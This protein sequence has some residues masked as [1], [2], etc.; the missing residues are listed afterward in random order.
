M[1]QQWLHRIF[2][3]IS[4]LFL[5]YSVALPAQHLP[6]AGELIGQNK[7]EEARLLLEKAA[8]QPSNV[9][10]ATLSLALLD[11]I[12]DHE[13]NLSERF[14]SI[15]DQENLYPYYYALWRNPGLAG[16][17]GL[18]DEGETEFI[19]SLLNDPKTP[20]MLRASAKYHLYH[21]RVASGQ[22]KKTEGILDGVSNISGWQYTGP[23]ENISESGFDKE[24]PPVMQYAADSRFKAMN[25]AD[26]QWFK[27][28]Y[29]YP[30]PWMIV[31][32]H[33]K[34]NVGLAY[35]Q[36]FVTSPAEMDVVISS[37]F[38]GTSLKVW[39][40]DQQ[41]IAEREERETDFDVYQ[42]PVHLQK[43]VNRVL[44]QIGLVSGDKTNFSARFLDKSGQVV[45]GLVP[46]S[47]QPYISQKNVPAPAPI[48]VFAEAWFEERIRENPNDWMSMYYLCEAYLRSDKYREA[49]VLA[50]RMLEKYPDALL[51]RYLRLR[52]YQG[53]NNRTA[54]TQELEDFRRI[55]PGFLVSAIYS[56]KEAG[57]NE[58]YEEAQKIL[59]RWVNRYDE[60]ETT[61][62]KQIELY[63]ARKQYQEAI[64]LIEDAV[65]KYPEN[66]YFTTLQHNVEMQV[67]KRPNAAISVYE[68]FLKRNYTF[69]IA[70]ALAS[71]Y[72]EQGMNRKAIDTY[73]KLDEIFRGETVSANALFSFYY[74][75][76]DVE[77]AQIWLDKLLSIAPYHS[78][79]WEKAG[80]LAERAKDKEKALE[81]Y[82]KALHYDPNEYDA[83]RKIRELQG[84][85][86]IQSLFPQIDAFALYKK[87][88]DSHNTAEFGWYY[89]L[90]DY[91]AIL[92]PER[93]S[94]SFHTLV[95]KITNEE[96]INHWKESS[97][98]YG[99]NQRLVIEKAEILKPGGSRIAA[100]Q[101]DNSLVFPNLEIG[102]GIYVRYRLS[103]YAFGRMAR[104]HFDTYFLNSQVPSELNRFVLI[105]PDNIPLRFRNWNTAAQPVE[106][107]IEGDNMKSWTWEL[108][109][110]Q[111]V[112]GE[113]NTAPSSDIAQVVHISSLNSWDEVASWYADVSATQAKP[114]YEVQQLYQELFPKGT[115]FTQ[116]EKAKA[117]YRWI[118]TNIR[119]SSVPFRQSGFIP[120]KAAKV[121]QTKLGDCKDL[122]TLYAA[123]A[124]EAGMKANL[125]LVN[126]RDEGEHAMEL[127]SIEFNHCI[128]KV[129][130]DETPYYLELTNPELPFAALSDNDLNAFVLEIPF[131][132][133]DQVR[134]EP[135]LLDPSNRKKDRRI[136]K[137]AIE[138]KGRELT[139][140]T[141]AMRFGGK[142]ADTRNN[143][144]NLPANKQVEEIQRSIAGRFTN[145]VAVKSMVFDNI[146]PVNDTLSYIVKYNVK[147]EIM[148]IGGL[149][150]F[151]VPFF[152]TFVNADLVNLEERKNPLRYWGYEDTDEY[153][154]EITIKLP[155]G[156]SFTEIPANVNLRF[157][158]MTY[159]L[160]YQKTAPDVLKV[161]RSISPQRSVITAGQ[162]PAFRTFVE[163]VV[164]AET[165]WVAYK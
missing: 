151:K 11:L 63:L 80:Q 163:E 121:I 54:L 107:T 47:S 81:Y 92:Y 108:K 146:T 9:K 6:Q 59:D 118:L 58:Q 156:K 84:K 41:V 86:D 112:P 39:V 125:V 76:N 97:I 33:I 57:D 1:L 19:E 73:T 138:I 160:T 119:Y 17:Y 103:N 120:Q 3:P 49:L 88:D 7:F 46:T 141:R 15:A 105:A 154:E 87:A 98:G 8:A 2:Y 16:A 104:E 27:P 89:V 129:I 53:L 147:N 26:I 64:E 38:T 144:K 37:G 101:N 117:I 115:Q 5:F 152:N 122:S 10:E 24:Y 44:V 18:K 111:P 55:D 62:Q 157:E 79:F 134:R 142:A 60:D 135:F 20:E 150:T 158:G 116:M 140:E 14:S 36:A 130:I 137:T 4:G 31:G 28:K 126:T 131:G 93:T 143:Y 77:N 32:A 139:V 124:R 21:H 123:L 133:N 136:E 164:N 159:Q 34:W 61:T 162:Y 51:Y 149:T 145:T 13:E 35:A 96:G 25:N 100:E 56:L 68:K 12:T 22:F 29:E 165:R 110:P 148:E 72:L 114:E 155:A 99:N 78:T 45:Q 82:Q 106:K 113:P 128:V 94:E 69:N 42:A 95:I 161:V 83:R 48:P 40:N 66:P 127:P 74:N 43:G 91:S 67:N 30:S 75:V 132:K 153:N 65:S 85:E 50:N 70:M 71:D 52:C 109:L 23:F 102:D 90:D